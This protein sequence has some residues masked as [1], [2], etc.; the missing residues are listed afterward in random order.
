MMLEP[1]FRG[2]SWVIFVPRALV[3]GLAVH[4]LMQRY[5]KMRTPDPI[6]YEKYLI[7]SRVQTH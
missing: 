2:G 3:D 4:R 6:K 5:A 1:S 7:E